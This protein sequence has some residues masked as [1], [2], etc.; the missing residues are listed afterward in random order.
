[1]AAAIP[2]QRRRQEAMLGFVTTIDSLQTGAKQTHFL[3][4]DNRV[5]PLYGSMND[6]PEGLYLGLLHGR[7]RLD[8]RLDRLGYPGPAIGPLRHVRTAYA[9]HLYLR[10]ADSE[11]ARRFFPL[12]CTLQEQDPVIGLQE[13]IV[14]DL[15]ESTIPYDGQFFGDWTVFYHE[16]STRQP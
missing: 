8:S 9:A 15:V 12:D 7:N 14:I 4:S 6:T 3:C 13:E 11:T 10:F 5:L 2:R 16:V 1:M